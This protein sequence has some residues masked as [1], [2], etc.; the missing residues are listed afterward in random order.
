MYQYL[1]LLCIENNIL[2]IQNS[3]DFVAR[4]F[5]NVNKK[6][7]SGRGALYWCQLKRLSSCL[8]LL[9]LLSNLKT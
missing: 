6:S 9:S 8:S 5:A 1:S 4:Y 3:V 7:T 2:T